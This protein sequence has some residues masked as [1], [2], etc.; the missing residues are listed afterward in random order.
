MKSLLPLLL[1]LMCP[2]IMVFMMRGM[3]GGDHQNAQV[4]HSSSDEHLSVDE[5]VA[6]RADLDS[7]LQTLNGRIDAIEAAETRSEAASV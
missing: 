5:L 2:L 7:R 4:D 6:L 3:H 1:V